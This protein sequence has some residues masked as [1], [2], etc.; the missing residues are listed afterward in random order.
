MNMKINK[1][2]IAIIFFRFVSIYSI[3]KAV[4]F[5]ANKS[6]YFFNPDNYTIIIVIQILTP[7]IIMLLCAVILWRIA[8]LIVLRLS[9]TADQEV[10]FEGS[11]DDLY[12]VAFSTIGLFIIV[13]SIPEM[14]NFVSFFSLD[15]SPNKSM[16]LLGGLIS[17]IGWFGKL[18]LG[19]WLIIGTKKIIKLVRSLRHE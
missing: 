5:F 19:I 9:N 4:E 10:T 1:D 13:E 15:Q 17:A 18:F 7:S 14:I 11:Q 6:T 12:E 16:L 2:T 8:P 3:V